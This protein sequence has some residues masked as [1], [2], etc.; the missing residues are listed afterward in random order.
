MHQRDAGI[1]EGHVDELALAR[2]RPLHQRH[3]HRDRGVEPG[4]DVDQRNA[5]PGRPAVGLASGGMP[6]IEN[7]PTIAWITA[8]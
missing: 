2:A 1:V 3:Q 5:D 7:M 8:S 4:A 6:L